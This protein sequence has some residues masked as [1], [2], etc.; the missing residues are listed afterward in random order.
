MR[1]SDGILGI[2]YRKI[3]CDQPM[4]EFQLQDYKS[5]VLLD[6]KLDQKILRLATDQQKMHSYLPIVF[7]E[8]VQPMIKAIRK[9]MLQYVFVAEAEIFT[10]DLHFKMFDSS[11]QNQYKG[12]EG[13][14]KHE[15][16]SENLKFQLEQIKKRFE[17]VYTELLFRPEIQGDRKNLAV[18]VYLATYFDENKSSQ[19][20][21]KANRKCS[22]F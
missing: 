17:K 14:M 22:Y 20:Y 1:Q 5:S 2:L 4:Y 12:G 18:A 6:Y 21:F 19:L 7:S 13:P 15:D 3:S 8:I 11:T 9:L 16:A 10:S